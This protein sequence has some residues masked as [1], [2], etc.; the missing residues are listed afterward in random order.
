MKEKEN[1]RQQGNP[2]IIKSYFINLYTTNYKIYKRGGFLDRQYLR[3]LNQ[4]RKNN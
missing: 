1:N 2:K 4:D 3:N